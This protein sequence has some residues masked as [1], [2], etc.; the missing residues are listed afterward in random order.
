MYAP[1]GVYD[2]RHIQYIYTDH[3]HVI[4]TSRLPTS[5]CVGLSCISNASRTARYITVYAGQ[6]AVITHE[7]C[8]SATYLFQAESQVQGN[9]WQKFIKY[10]EE[11]YV[12]LLQCR[13]HK[14]EKH[15]K[16]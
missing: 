9:V 12:V 4:T 15:K 5:G 8:T 13:D 1:R 7:M 3:A 14:M 10:V 11:I 6:V 2:R 16:I